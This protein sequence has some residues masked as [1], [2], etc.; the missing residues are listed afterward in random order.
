MEVARVLAA[1]NIVGES[2]VWSAA[3]GA[4]YWVDIV[5]KYLHRLKGEQLDSWQMPEWTC[6][7]TPTARG[8]LLLALTHNLKRFD[9][10]TQTLTDWLSLSDEPSEN[11]N[12]ELKCD[13]RGR[14][15]LGTMQNNIAPDGS[16]T[17]ITASSGALYCISADKTIHQKYTGVGISNTLAWSPD[18][19]HFYFADSLANKL[20]RFDIDME[21]AVLSEQTTFFSP[22]DLGA[23]DGSAMDA[24]GYV[25]NTRFGAGCVVRL[26]PDGRVDTR[27]DLAAKNPTSCA[28]GGD[29]LKTLYITSARFGLTESELDDDQ[30]A[31][32]ALQVDTPGLAVPAFD[33]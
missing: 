10:D 31:L 25:W 23:P 28:F 22:D 13:P 19:Q 4:L 1:R 18:E 6:G 16:G 3:E 8:D 33:I 12:N 27:I 14:L 2:P 5:G 20:W 30:G 29:D 15:W 26:A 17:D 21:T 11:R 7:V 24:E 32:F 9:T